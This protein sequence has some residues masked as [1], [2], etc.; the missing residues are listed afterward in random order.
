MHPLAAIVEIQSSF[1]N[2]VCKQLTAFLHIH[3]LAYW[4]SLHMV[5]FCAF[6]E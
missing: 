1:G 6:H 3:W 4:I 2:N 5:Y